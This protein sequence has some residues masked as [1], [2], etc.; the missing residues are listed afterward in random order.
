MR[1]ELIFQTFLLPFSSVHKELWYPFDTAYFFGTKG[2]YLSE[3]HSNLKATS[4][5]PKD[6]LLLSNQNDFCHLYLDLK[7]QW[8]NKHENKKVHIFNRQASRGPRQLLA[9]E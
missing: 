8:W 2:Y 6:F 9:K 7:N 1:W 3:Y 4:H 5:V